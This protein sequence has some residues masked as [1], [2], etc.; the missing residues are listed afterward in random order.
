MEVTEV[1]SSGIAFSLSYGFAWVQQYYQL[2]LLSVWIATL[3]ESVIARGDERV[4][5]EL[6]AH[7]AVTD[8]RELVV[9]GVDLCLLVGHYHVPNVAG[10]TIVGFAK[11]RNA[12]LI[13]GNAK[14]K[15][16]FALLVLDLPLQSLARI[17]LAL[18][19]DHNHVDV[20]N[21]E[22]TISDVLFFRSASVSGP[23]HLRLPTDETSSTLESRKNVLWNSCNLSNGGFHDVWGSSA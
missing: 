7:V 16:I 5:H 9:C 6:Q 21:P 18:T 17:A 15:V 3:A 2:V 19:I 1:L 22:Q 11:A 14:V 10:L 8:L 12:L 23:G 20:K 4:N 13:D